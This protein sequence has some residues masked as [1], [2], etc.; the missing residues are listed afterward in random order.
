M[1]RFE[2][3]LEQKK[4]QNQYRTFAN[5][6]HHG[7]YVEQS[8][9]MMLNLSGNDY[10]GLAQ[11]TELSA[12]F[13]AVSADQL[14]AYTSS[15][16][17]LLTGNFPIY[18][19]LE[20]LLAERFGRQSALIFNSG[21]HANIG[22][23]PALANKQTLIVADKLV[24]ASL[25]DGI[26][27]SS[28][29]LIRYRHNDY[30]HLH[31]ILT[32]NSPHF[33][34]IVIVTES[35]FS[36]DGDMANLRLLVEFKHQFPKVLLYVDEAHA[37]GIY[38]ETGLGLAQQAGCI[39]QIDLLVGTFGKA[40]ASVGA[41][42]ICDQVIKDYLINTMRPLIFST[43]LP[44]F[45]VAWTHFLFE[46]LPHFTPQRKQLAHLSSRLRKAVAARQS[47]PSTSHIVPYILG[48]NLKTVEKSQVLQT[49]GYYCLPIRPPT[50]PQGT[51]RIR[52]S[53]TAAMTDMELS[54]L[55]ECL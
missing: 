1:K 21:Y 38:G 34:H 52:F 49:L 19:Q 6:N 14:P 10:L 48:D 8:G 13:L 51:S 28:A 53:L 11:N 43:A 35:I 42:L 31:Y 15:S 20:N 50:V 30:D 44:P 37:I 27:L 12:E 24:H 36:M 5:L 17:R 23:L 29:P 9:K 45:N 40:L 33:E 4:A 39:E 47:H 54:H 46:K 26:R 22:I 18:N 41:Y 7:K 32:K 25:L 55:I 16:S 3:I 2:Q